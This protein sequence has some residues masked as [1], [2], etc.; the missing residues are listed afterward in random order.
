MKKKPNDKTNGPHQMW[1]VKRMAEIL[2]VSE[3]HVRREIEDGKL[4]VYR[5]GRA[6]RISD[7]DLKAYIAA[8]R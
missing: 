2:D 4:A 5:F 8:S 1:T 6:I 3:R 7:E